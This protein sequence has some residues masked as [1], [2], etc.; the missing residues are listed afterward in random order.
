MWHFLVNEILEL[1]H[2]NFYW[3]RIKIDVQKL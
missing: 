2:E 1:F 3:P